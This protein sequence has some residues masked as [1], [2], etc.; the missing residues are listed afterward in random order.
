MCIRHASRTSLKDETIELGC[1]T[2]ACTCVVPQWGVG[3]S[4]TRGKLGLRAGVVPSCRTQRPFARRCD[5]V[6]NQESAI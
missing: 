3:V 5:L 4:V 2:S 6:L 1:C